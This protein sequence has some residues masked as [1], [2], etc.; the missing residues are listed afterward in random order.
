MKLKKNDLDKSN[1]TPQVIFYQIN[2]TRTNN[3]FLP[4]VHKLNFAF[5][6]KKKI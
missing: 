1:E 3:W 4:H 2:L 5:L 6:V